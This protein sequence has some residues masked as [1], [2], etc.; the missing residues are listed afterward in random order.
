MCVC[1]LLLQ[2]SVAVCIGFLGA[3][4]PYA[5]VAMWAAFVDSTIIPPFAF[6]LAAIFAKSST[7]YNPVVYL[8]FKPNFRK[9]LCRD[10]AQFRHKICSST[11]KGS[12]NAGLKDPSKP[13]SSQ[14]N[15]K[16]M[17]N[18]TRLSNG[19]PESH[20]ACLHCAEVGGG[21]GGG[22]GA[23]RCHLTTP[24]RTVRVLTD[25]GHSE[26]MVCQLPDKI[27]DNFL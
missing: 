12:P 1:V 8:L 17:S 19:L 9:S 13:A 18:S 22:G 2:L 7:I 10:T 23:T 4:S 16:D 20:G 21:G 27:H 24:Q 6:A 11:G 25:S 15:N 3:W 5:V 26:V 14:R